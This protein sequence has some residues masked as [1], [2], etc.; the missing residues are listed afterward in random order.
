M[1][2]RARAF[3]LLAI[4]TIGCQGRS[5]APTSPSPVSS[6]VSVAFS[7][8]AITGVV[9]DLLQRPVG[10]VRIEVTEG[11]SSGRTAISDAQGQFSLDAIASGD[12]VAVTVSKDG[13]DTVMTRLRAGQ[14]VIFLRDV[15]VANL[16]GRRSVRFT[17][18]ASCVQLPPALRTRS[19][20]AVVIN[21]TATAAVMK[22]EATFVSELGG[23]DF[24]QGYGTMWLIAA[25]DAV[26]FNVFSWDAFNWWLEDD[27][28]IE[29][30]TPTSHLSI[31]GMATTAVSSHQSTITTT[32]D[33]TFSFCAE[34]KPGAQPQW[35]P[36]CAVPPVE[37]TS[38]RHQLT[39]TAP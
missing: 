34:S 23:A 15:S 27:P 4:F 2:H 3:V 16:E 9:R 32:L 18:D 14:A 25:H 1:I 26:R 12:R 20:G 6:P 8:V 37:C 33:G 24:Y 7:A 31:S 36:T 29:R 39:M 11:P 13:Y 22:G 21:S 38:P 10:D 5:A 17:A 35:P 19:Y 28:I 30:L